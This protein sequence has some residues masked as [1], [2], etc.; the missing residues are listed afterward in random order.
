MS[1]FCSISARPSS[2]RT[3]NGASLRVRNGMCSACAARRAAWRAARP[4]DRCLG[5]SSISAAPCCL[6]RPPAVGDARRDRPLRRPSPS[7]TPCRRSGN[8]TTR[9]RLGKAAV[10]CGKA[11]ASTKC[12]W[13][14]G[15]TAVSIFSTRRTTPSISVGPRRTAARSAR[16]FP[17]RCRPIGRWR[18]RSRGSGRGSSRGSDRSGCRTPRRAGSRRP[19]RRRAGPSAAGRR[20]RAP[21]WRAGWRGRRSG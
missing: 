1:A 5:V 6:R 21:P 11:I 17:R 3:S 16:R 20:R 12:S 15:S 7:A 14:R 19:H 9:P 18:D 8:G 2:S 10:W 4:P 13:K